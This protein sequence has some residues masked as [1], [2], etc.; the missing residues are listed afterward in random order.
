MSYAAD[1]LKQAR[2][3]LIVDK[4]RPKQASI[5]RS[6]STA[7]YAV[8]HLLSDDAAARI[9]TGQPA[10][11]VNQARR[12]LTHTDMA[13]AAKGLIGGT[14]PKAYKPHFSGPVNPSLTAFA[15]IFNDLQ[16]ARHTADYDLSER[17]GRSDAEIQV[18]AAEQAFVLW[19]ALRGTPEANLF[20][21]MLYL[22]KPLQGR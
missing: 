21:T 20:L 9:C 3:L 1:L 7:Y 15:T 8:F 2:H 17:I 14:L 5:R 10:A 11:L 4:T 19:A 22:W 12:A 6:I 18:K 13:N 16:Q